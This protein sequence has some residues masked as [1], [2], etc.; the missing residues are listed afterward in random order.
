[1]HNACARVHGVSMRTILFHLMCAADILRM[2]E[3]K[4][5]K[6]AHLHYLRAHTLS[7]WIRTG[8]VYAE[9]GSAASGSFKSG[10]PSPSSPNCLLEWLPLVSVA[11]SSASGPA[12]PFYPGAG[13]KGAGE[14]P[15]S[16]SGVVSGEGGESGGEKGWSGGVLTMEGL[17]DILGAHLREGGNESWSLSRSPSLS[18]ACC[19]PASQPASPPS[20][21]LSL[22]DTTHTHTHAR[23]R[24]CTGGCSCA[25]Q[26]ASDASVCRSPRHAGPLRCHQLWPLTSCRSH[27]EAISTFR[28]WF[29][30]C[31]REERERDGGDG[32]H[33][34]TWTRARAHTH[35][36]TRT[37]TLAC[38]HPATHGHTSM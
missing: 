3:Q 32:T 28:D 35:T 36:H 10:D 12:V 4:N 1:M 33:T 2:Y 18:R 38:M 23:E 5:A 6:C 8:L 26:T 22:S 9:L 24:Q 7:S 21:S 27:L 25:G 37:C 31:L 30:R 16:N 13:G 29:V 20:P 19:L 15:R 34:H 11:L 14:T 17:L